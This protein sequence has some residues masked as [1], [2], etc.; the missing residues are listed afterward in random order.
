MVTTR[1]E[2]AAGVIFGPAEAAMAVA[3]LDQHCS[4]DRLHAAPEMI[5]RIAAAAL[6]KSEGSLEKL[7]AAMELAARDWR[8]LLMAAGFGYD[9]SAHEAWFRQLAQQEAK[10]R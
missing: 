9:V 6:K 5:E 10:V 8:D 3:R 2:S 4:A 1:L 7:E